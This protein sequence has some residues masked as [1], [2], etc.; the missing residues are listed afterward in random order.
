VPV[1]I[2]I[3]VDAAAQTATPW[4][5]DGTGP[6]VAAVN[7]PLAFKEGAA[8]IKAVPHFKI[9]SRDSKPAGNLPDISFMR[10]DERHFVPPAGGTR[11]FRD[12]HRRGGDN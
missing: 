12:G 1:T 8:F 10:M 5:S 2:R 4:K 9:V 3:Q 7:Y 6:P 11:I